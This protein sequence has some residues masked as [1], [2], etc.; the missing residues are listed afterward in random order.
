MTDQT[1]TDAAKPKPRTSLKALKPLID[2]RPT[3][4]P[5]AG[6]NFIHGDYTPTLYRRRDGRHEL[7][8]DRHDTSWLRAERRLIEMVET[9]VNPGTTNVLVTP[10]RSHLPMAMT[11][12]MRHGGQ[13]HIYEPRVERAAL[14]Q[15]DLLEN[16]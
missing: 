12:K 14:I 5:H 9:V 6:L 3:K 11:R 8:N 7:V 16:N 15:V 4:H 1:Q 10:G 2:E 13:L